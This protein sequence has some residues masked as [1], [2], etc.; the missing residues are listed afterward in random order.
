MKSLVAT[1]ISNAHRFLINEVIWNHL[2]IQ[3]EEG[4]QTW[5]GDP[6]SVT[7]SNP[8]ISMIHHLSSFQQQ[9]CDEYANQ[10]ING[11][12]A[13]F[14]YTYHDRLFSYDSFSISGN[15]IIN[16]IDRL[17]DHLKKEP[18]TRRAIAITWNPRYDSFTPEKEDSVPCLQM[19]QYIFRNNKLN[20]IA[21]FRS[22]DILSAAGPNM[23]G[24]VRLQEH[25]ASALSL[26]V[27]S[28]THIVTIPHMYPVRDAADLQRWM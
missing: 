6:V 20:C 8:L 27:G 11:V 13:E 24:L 25:V 21:V 19:V 22:N 2:D 16:Q 23:Y 17:I 7:I 10:L 15:K 1:S 28:Y 3:T 9:K 26:P 4:E 14:D 18:E 12:F 5:E